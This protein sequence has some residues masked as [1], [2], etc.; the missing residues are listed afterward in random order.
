[1][2]IEYDNERDGTLRGFFSYGSTN[3]IKGSGA[4]NLDA[5]IVGWEEQHIHSWFPNIG[6]MFIVYNFLML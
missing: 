4:C 3:M 6:A 1:M 2:R 5:L